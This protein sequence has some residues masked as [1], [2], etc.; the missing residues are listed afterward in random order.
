MLYH[1]LSPIF[2]AFLHRNLSRR[3]WFFSKHGPWLRRITRWNRWGHFNPIVWTMKL[4]WMILISSLSEDHYDWLY[5]GF[6]TIILLIK[7]YERYGQGLWWDHFSE[8]QGSNRIDDNR[9]KRKLER[10]QLQWKIVYTR[11]W[12][13]LRISQQ[14]QNERRTW[15]DQHRRIKGQN[16]N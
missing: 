1:W 16:S 6:L 11:S 13:L 12:S 7:S 3:A 10:F 8:D 5:K 4:A 9:R 15:K 14:N 2:I